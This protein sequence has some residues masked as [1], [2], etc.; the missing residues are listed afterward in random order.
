MADEQYPYLQKT[1]LQ[2][3]FLFTAFVVAV[4]LV[5]IV[6]IIITVLGRIRALLLCQTAD[7]SLCCELFFRRFDD[8]LRPLYLVATFGC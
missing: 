3:V 5:P 8:V 6:V 2:F 1:I 4:A 7:L